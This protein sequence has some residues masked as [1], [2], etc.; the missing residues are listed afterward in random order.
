LAGLQRDSESVGKVRFLFQGLLTPGRGL[1]QLLTAWTFVPENAQLVFRGPDGEFKAAL[2]EMAGKLGLPHSAVIFLPP[3]GEDDLVTGAADFDVGLIPY[4]PINN[5]NANCCPNKLSQYMAAGLAILA[6]NTNFVR[7][8]VSDARCGLIV[9]FAQTEKLVQ[10]VTR[11]AAN[12]DD[13]AGMASNARHYFADRFNWGAI[14]ESMYSEILDMSASEEP[15]L[16]VAWPQGRYSL[17]RNGSSWGDD[18]T[19]ESGNLDSSEPATADSE[20]ATADS[21]PATPDSAH[22]SFARALWHGLP[23]GL[24]KELRPVLRWILGKGRR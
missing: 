18:F 6:N 1:E 23:A 2:R 4:P 11:L 17:Y 3:V 21:E 15:E 19:A 16:L 10:A 5:N 9:D 14:S 12:C 8:V 7:E 22:T 24:R 13:R 20:P